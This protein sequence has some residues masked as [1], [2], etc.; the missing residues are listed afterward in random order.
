MALVV[1]S[2][3]GSR[4]PGTAHTMTESYLP[5]LLRLGERARNLQ[6]FLYVACDFPDDDPNATLVS[7][8]A[9]PIVRNPTANPQWHWPAQCRLQPKAEALRAACDGIRSPRCSIEFVANIGREA[10]LYLHHLLRVYASPDLAALTFFV[11][12]GEPWGL[13]H[14]FECAGGVHESARH[15]ARRH[16]NRTEEL[17]SGPDDGAACRASDLPFAPAD[18][19][20]ASPHAGTC[21]GACRKPDPR[22]A[23]MLGK[24]DP[25]LLA[26]DLPT[27][28]PRDADLERCG[29]FYSSPAPR[30]ASRVA[31]ALVRHV[32]GLCALTAA[33]ANASSSWP[34]SARGAFIVSRE[35]LRRAPLALYAELYALASSPQIELEPFRT[36][37]PCSAR[38]VPPLRCS[39][40]YLAGDSVA[41][42]LETLWAIVFGAVRA[43][44]ASECVRFEEETATRTVATQWGLVVP[45]GGMWCR[46]AGVRYSR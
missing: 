26:C 21:H 45:R 39:G 19:Y 7:T 3:A 10:H 6:V 11:Q 30:V 20:F 17:A 43:G 35:A 8:R 25:L 44:A 4:S 27:D 40:P 9:P 15:S 14:I 31:S 18:V 16:G 36:V 38:C 12:E 22:R 46:R 5:S 1:A 42:L 29:H 34:I 32:G 41:Y 24:L 2:Y 23:D 13:Q 28:A 37:P 33:L